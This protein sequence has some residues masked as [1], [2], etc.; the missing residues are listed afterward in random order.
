M[1]VEALE[2]MSCIS[3]ITAFGEALKQGHLPACNVQRNEQTAHAINPEPHLQVIPLPN[4]GRKVFQRC[5][6]KTYNSNGQQKQKKNFVRAQP[7]TLRRLRGLLN[8]RA[9]I[10]TFFFFHTNQIQHLC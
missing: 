6:K 4:F 5:R 1:S 3:A 8:R 9:S 10:K 7:S 2:R